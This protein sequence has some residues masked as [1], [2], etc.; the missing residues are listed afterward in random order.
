MQKR[1]IAKMRIL[2]LAL[3][4]KICYTS[5]GLTIRELQ[6]NCRKCMI[7]GLLDGGRYD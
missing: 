4:K 1:E 3:Y 7:S 5:N 2:K 6:R